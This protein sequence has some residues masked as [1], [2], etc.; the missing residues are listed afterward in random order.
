MSMNEADLQKEYTR[1]ETSSFADTANLKPGTDLLCLSCNTPDGLSSCCYG[2]YKKFTDKNVYNWKCDG[3]AILGLPANS[4]KNFSAD[5][6]CLNN[7]KQTTKEEEP[8]RLWSGPKDW[9]P[10]GKDCTAAECEGTCDCPPPKVEEK[11]VERTITTP[12]SCT[13]IKTAKKTVIKAIEKKKD[14][15]RHTDKK[16]PYSACSNI[17]QQ[18]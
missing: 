4:L 6:I 12:G 16:Q 11:L 14:E 2:N 7:G 5:K 18:L 9:F 13:D 15:I 3:K 17:V 10:F 8:D 1:I